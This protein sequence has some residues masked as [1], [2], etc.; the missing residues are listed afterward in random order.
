MSEEMKKPEL[1]SSPIETTEHD[2][3]KNLKLNEN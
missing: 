1:E 3:I 2:N